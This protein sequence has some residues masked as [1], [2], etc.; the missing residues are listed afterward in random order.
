MTITG[1]FEHFQC[2]DFETTF[3]KSKKPFES[4][5]VESITIES[6]AFPYKTD[7][8]KANVKTSSMGS[9]K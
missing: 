3:L 7:L 9:T 4:F 6:T 8:L 5:L 1:G 2:F